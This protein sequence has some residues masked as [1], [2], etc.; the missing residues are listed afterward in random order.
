M[1]DQYTGPG[2][3]PGRR[4]DRFARL[5]RG[6]PE[7]CAIALLGLP[8]DG[9]VALNGGRAGAADGPRAFRAAPGLSP[10]HISEPTR[11]D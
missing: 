2:G 6:E 7:G 10:I 11:P 9:G 4:P 5:V 8:F 3:W 1:R